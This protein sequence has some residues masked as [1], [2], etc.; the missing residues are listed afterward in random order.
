M[1][2]EKK[3]TEGIPGQVSPVSKNIIYIAGISIALVI[4]L[5][6]S[7]LYHA[8]FVNID[9]YKYI[10]ENEHIKDMSI[11]GLAKIFYAPGPGLYIPIVYLSW[12]VEYSISG[13]D[14]HRYHTDN[15]LLHI[16][17]SLLVLWLVWLLTKNL[18][19]SVSMAGLFALHPLH[20]ESVAWVSE[21]KDVLYALFYLVSIICYHFYWQKNQRKYYWFCFILFLLSCMSKPM[22]ISL[23]VV[24]LIYD[25]FY[26]K[27]RSWKILTGKIP[28]LLFFLFVGV[29]AVL[30]NPVSFSKN[31]GLN[32]TLLDRAILVLYSIAFYVQKS[33]LPVNLSAMYT[34]PEKTGALLPLY[35]IVCAL[36]ALLIAG[37]IALSK[38]S[39]T[40]VKACFLFFLV[41]IFPMLQF[42]PH[43]YTITA[44]RYTYIPAL[45]IFGIIVYYADKLIQQ[46]RISERSAWITMVVILIT[47]SIATYNRC[48]VWANG[49]SLGS[50]IVKKGQYLDFAICSLGDLYKKN[51]EPLKA[52]AVYQHADSLYP[53]RVAVKVRYA[54]MLVK[55]GQYDKAIPQYLRCLTLDSTV[56]NIYV[57]LGDAYF[58]TGKKE[59]ALNIFLKGLSLSPDDNGCLY[60]VGYTYLSMGNDSEAIKYFRKAALNK[61]QPAIDFFNKNNISLN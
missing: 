1:K 18:F 31:T 61:Y 5:A 4:S 35:Y 57:N 30:T 48:K 20:V 36:F 52:L 42:I 39:S 53:D 16:I 44:D 49:I 14:P 17:N 58:N 32:F 40:L 12:A 47:L 46:K 23:P 22:A 27:K 50:D 29:V 15:V 11:E 28:F 59:E 51:G 7:S 2:K 56:T 25:Y 37:F 43:T 33:L 60:N 34:F 45:G 8:D 24:L 38:Y 19:A 26:L 10:N 6:F 21:R 13:L 54:D 41:T 3:Q 55:V 9:D